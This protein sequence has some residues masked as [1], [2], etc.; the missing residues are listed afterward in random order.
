MNQKSNK[1]YPGLFALIN[2]KK[3]SGYRYLFTTIKRIITL[4]NTKNLKL[5][6]ITTDFGKGLINAII[7]VFPCVKLIGCFYHFVRAV[8]ENFK[9]F[10]HL[11]NE[12]YGTI[13]NDVFNLPFSF[14]SENYTNVDAFCNKYRVSFPVFIGYFD[15]QWL[16]YFKKWNVKL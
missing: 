10:T 6:H 11:K 2:N 4:E 9:R 3:E 8:K 15:G 5:K 7:S 14:S 16:Q 13:L 1:R 12:F